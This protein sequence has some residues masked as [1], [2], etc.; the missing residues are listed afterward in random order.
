MNLAFRIIALVLVATTAFSNAAF[1]CGVVV[2]K[3][4]PALKVKRDVTVVVR[5]SSTPLKDV[6]LSVV[7]EQDRE[8]IRRASTDERGKVEL[9]DLPVGKYVID[10][11]VG[12]QD[13]EVT[14]NSEVSTVYV[15]AEVGRAP[16]LLSKVGG[17]VSDV[18][19]APIPD[20]VVVVEQ[21]DRG[22]TPVAAQMS[23]SSGHIN[24]NVPSGVYVMR[25]ASRGFR[26]ATVPIQ[27]D[28]KGWSSFR[29]GLQVASCEASG[30]PNYTGYSIESG[31]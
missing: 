3:S 27:V 1:A 13:I 18:T 14:N 11:A 4:E 23:D 7:R 9:H 10:S 20:A 31:E 28:Q 17:T 21:L 26:T 30:Q 16:I 15:S 5:H 24:L 8:T 29:L 25:V 2:I 19:G 12:R 6:D 22:R